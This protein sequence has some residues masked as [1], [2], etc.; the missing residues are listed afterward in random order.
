M[1][2]YLLFF[3]GILTMCVPDDAGLTRF[4][5]QGAIG[6]IMMCVGAYLMIQEQETR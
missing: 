2:K 4:A 1:L 3:A 5:I 6:L